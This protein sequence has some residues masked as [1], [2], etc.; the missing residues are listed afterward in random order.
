MISSDRTASIGRAKFEGIGMK[1]NALIAVLGKFPPRGRG[2]DAQGTVVASA[3]RLRENPKASGAC[4]SF[5]HTRNQSYSA[6]EP[7]LTS[8]PVA[9]LVRYVV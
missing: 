8:G 3:G 6:D 1:T 9:G 5:G 7:C 2:A 4:F